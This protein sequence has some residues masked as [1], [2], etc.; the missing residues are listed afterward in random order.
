M[1]SFDNPVLPN[2]EVIVA[3]VGDVLLHDVVQRTAMSQPD[4]FAGLWRPVADLLRAAHV[5][6]ANLE[7]PVAPG[8]AVDGT[9]VDHPVE[10]FDGYVY[11]GYPMFNYPSAVIPALAQAG[12]DIVSTANNHSLDRYAIGID[13][14]IEQ[15]R[16]A[17][18]AHTGTRMRTETADDWHAITETGDYRIAWLACTYGT[19]GIEDRDR[20]V[21]MCYEHRDLILDEITRLSTRPDIDAVI[22]TPHW[23][24]EYTHNP[25]SRQR[26]LAHQAIEAGAT[27][28]IG[29]HPHVVQPFERYRGSD[30]RE[31]FIAYSLGNF[32][33]NQRTLNRRSSLILL[34][35][36]AESPEGGLSVAAVR[37]VPIHVN[38][39]AGA[40]GTGIAVEAID[41]TGQGYDSRALLVD[42]LGEDGIAPPQPPFTALGDCGAPA[43]VAMSR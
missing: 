16:A 35:S 20:Q 34:L 43:A 15:L 10:G 14:T 1:L 31:R 6:Y 11:S 36:L 33:S 18:I 17:G 40:D 39:Q 41:R 22:F 30:G 8:V 32:V 3:A 28:V 13:R 37:W 5:T 27:A 26:E 25:L 42:L 12:V 23:G 2:T 7:G 24:E 19:N 4:G 38:F 9:L 21:L 29:N